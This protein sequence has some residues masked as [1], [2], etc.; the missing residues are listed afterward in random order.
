MTFNISK[1]LKLSIALEIVFDNGFG[2]RRG[3]S[4]K[5]LL[6][7]DNQNEI[8]AIIPLY[9]DNDSWF[10]VKRADLVREFAKI[11]VILR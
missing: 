10:Y 3:L 2:S 11:G 8:K 7:L 6:V 1:H 9:S 4:E 5:E